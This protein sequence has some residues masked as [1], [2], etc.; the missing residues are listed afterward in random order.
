MKDNVIIK[1][2]SPV[3][4]YSTLLT[5]DG[6]KKTYYYNPKESEFS[7][8]IAKN[9]YKKYIAFYQIEPQDPNF[10]IAQQSESR[11]E[12]KK[13]K[14]KS[15]IIKGWMGKFKLTASKEL[16]KTHKVLAAL[17]LLMEKYS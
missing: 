6:K 1:M 17:K 12:E 7:D 4:I 8:L 11:L 5:L 15:F 10:K 9:V 2:L 16:L 3:T 14:Y 13:I